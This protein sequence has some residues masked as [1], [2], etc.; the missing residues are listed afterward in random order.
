MFDPARSRPLGTRVAALLA[1]SVLLAGAGC[2]GS[3][4]ND[5]A[6]G[7][8][9]VLGAVEGLEGEARSVRLRELAQKEGGTLTLYTSLASEDEEEISSAFED[10]YD[11]D[12]SVY[13]ASDEAVSNGSPKARGVVPRRRRRRDGR[14]ELTILNKQS[15]LAPYEPRAGPASSRTS[16]NG[17]TPDR[18]N[19]FVVARN[20]DRVGPSDRPRSWEDLADPRWRG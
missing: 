10:A 15:I 8:E 14:H 18:F 7:L 5:E 19:T 9:E 16:Q 1:I 12:V 2:G 17:W 13:R 4:S 3:G 11:I 6:T 20:T